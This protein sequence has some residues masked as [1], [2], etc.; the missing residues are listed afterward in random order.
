MPCFLFRSEK[1]GDILV[2]EGNESESVLPKVDAPD[3][4]FGT[5]F[6][7]PYAPLCRFCLFTVVIQA[8]KTRV[9]LFFVQPFVNLSPSDLSSYGHPCIGFPPIRK[10]IRTLDA[11]T[12]SVTGRDPLRPP[13]FFLHQQV[14]LTTFAKC[15]RKQNRH[16]L[17]K[18][19]RFV[20]GILVLPEH[21]KM[22][23]GSLAPE[24]LRKITGKPD[25]FAIHDIDVSHISTTPGL[26]AFSARRVPLVQAV[27]NKRLRTSSLHDR[28]V[29]LRRMMGFKGR[30]KLA[31][32]KSMNKY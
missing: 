30:K 6:L 15:S 1:A 12:S 25:C 19:I 10:G 31:S 3:A 20:P 13:E 29:N 5:N 14:K 17:T 11:F 8:R 23:H 16:L 24:T 22:L 26:M 32:L 4:Y 21:H 28:R 2:H 7:A 9:E 18:Q 27:M